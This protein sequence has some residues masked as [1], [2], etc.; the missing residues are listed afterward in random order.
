MSQGSLHCLQLVQSAGVHHPCDSLHWLS[1]RIDF[2]F[3]SLTFK[4]LNG[5]A[6]EHIL[7]LLTCMFPFQPLTSYDRALLTTT[8]SHFASK[9]D[10]A[11]AMSWTFV[12]FMLIL[13]ILIWFYL[14]VCFY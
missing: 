8:R 9:G 14:V 1:F 12:L 7:D 5:F 6:P 4:A 3:V 13:F 2:K 11:F 10:R